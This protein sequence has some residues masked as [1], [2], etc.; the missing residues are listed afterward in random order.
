VQAA[1]YRALTHDIE[2]P[3]RGEWSDVT[4]RLYSLRAHALASFRRAVLDVLPSR[5][6]WPVHTN[7]ELVAHATKT[8]AD[9]P[10]E[11]LERRVETAYYAPD[12][13]AVDEVLAIE[14]LAEEVQRPIAHASTP[15]SGSPPDSEGVR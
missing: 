13:P 1:G 12:P 11:A 5:D 15:G 6:L 3:H 8:R 7:R 4:V 2:T 10:L 9:V 14:A